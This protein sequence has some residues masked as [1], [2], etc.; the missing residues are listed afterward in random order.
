MPSVLIADALSN[1]SRVK[2]RL[3]ISVSTYDTLIERHINSATAWLRRVCGRTSWLKATYTNEVYDGGDGYFSTLLLRNAPAVT[4]SLSSFQYRT[5][6]LS[7][8]TWVSFETDDYELEADLNAALIRLNGYLPAGN[9][10]IRVTYQAGYLIDF[11]N[12]ATATHTLPFD[13][14]DLCE[15]MVC[16]A[17][18]RRGSEG[19]TGE[20]FMGASISWKDTVD[21]IGREV[22]ASYMRPIFV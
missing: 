4:G 15:S 11:T 14:T 2:T 21:E 6:S 20:S 22:I 18:N 12:E 16:A 19:K 1:A 13:L 17:Y 5:G 3:G 7:S 9:N 10:N 8:P